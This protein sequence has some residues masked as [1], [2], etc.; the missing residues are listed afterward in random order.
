MCIWA[1][2]CSR[3]IR[4]TKKQ[5]LVIPVSC[6][7]LVIMN[8]YFQNSSTFCRVYWVLCDGGEPNR[9]FM[10]MLFGCSDS[11][12]VKAKF[13]AYHLFTGNEMVVMSDPKVCWLLLV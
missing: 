1:K 4:L 6:A 7:S 13:V 12:P 11:D 3:E 8:N 2:P 5:V 10:K 9:S